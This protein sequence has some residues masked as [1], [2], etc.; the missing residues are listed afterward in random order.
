MHAIL[1]EYGLPYHFPEEVEAEAA[2]AIPHGAARQGHQ[3]ARRR[4]SGRCPPSPSTPRTPRTLTMPSACADA[5]KR[6]PRSGCAHR[7]RHPLR[8]PG[9]PH[10]GRGRRAR[11]QRLPRG[12]HH[13]RCCRRSCPTTCAPCG[14]TR[15]VSP[16]VRSSS[17]TQDGVVVK[18]W[19]GRTVIHSDRRF[20]YAEAQESA[21]KPERE[22]WQRRCAGIAHAGPQ[23]A[24]PAVQGR[25]H[26]FRYRGGPLPAQ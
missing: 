12:P 3:V 1:L 21:W 14:P 8:A 19:F 20:T 22:T 18:E 25:G 13:T 16:S 10:R 4:T 15:T 23:N 17:S 11:H 2:E 26:R 6:P 7:R 9:R 24:G 5:R